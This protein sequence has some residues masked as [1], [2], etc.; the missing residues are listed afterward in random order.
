MFSFSQQF[1][2]YDRKLKKTIVI[3][4]RDLKIIPLLMDN[5]YKDRVK[6]AKRGNIYLT[7]RWTFVTIVWKLK[8]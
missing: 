1:T 4:M 8:Q 6:P 5:L 3:I 7:N 2:L